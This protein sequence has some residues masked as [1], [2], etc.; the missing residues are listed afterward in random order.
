M[1]EGF[2]KRGQITIFIILGL[3]ILVI[4]VLLFTGGGNIGSFFS[5]QSPVAQIERCV[6]D[7]F[8]GLL[9]KVGEQGGQINPQHYYLYEDKKVSYT[10]YTQESFKRCVMQRPFLERAIETELANYLKPK[11]E[12]CLAQTKES[13]GA[14]SV[15]Y[16][17]P[18]IGVTLSPGNVLVAI[19][20]DLVIADGE[21]R[22]SYEYIK[23]DFSSRLYDFAVVAGEITNNEVTFG[24]D[25]ID[26]Y[27]YK[28]K[29]LKVEK[30]KQGDETT[31][32]RLSDRGSDEKFL[33]AVRSLAIPPGWIEV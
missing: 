31:V 26:G 12:E 28:D 21:E 17:Q 14:E 19:K 11:I 9:D 7:D 29:T 5:G 15:N 4:V 2:L 22:Q 16:A 32:Y 20:V 33:F 27:M 18:Q 23:K 13:F 8:E 25:Q 1:Q 10:C 30:L 24:D 3:A 6:F